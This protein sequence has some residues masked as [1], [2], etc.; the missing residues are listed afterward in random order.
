MTCAEEAG[1]R[2]KEGGVDEEGE[3]IDVELYNKTK[4]E[5]MLARKTVEDNATEIENL[6]LQLEHMKGFLTNLTVIG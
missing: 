2:R 4:E 1:Q 6:K 3:T 5:L